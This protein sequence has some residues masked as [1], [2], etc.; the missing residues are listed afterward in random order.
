[1]K[2]DDEG[3][4]R[5]IQKPVHESPGFALP[6]QE[7]EEIHPGLRLQ[8]VREADD[9][10]QDDGKDFNGSLHALLPIRRGRRRFMRA[11]GRTIAWHT[12]VAGPATR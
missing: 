5:Q 6:A 1:M 9:T 11:R 12:G 10:K 3:S 8:D 7:D 2:R 4:E